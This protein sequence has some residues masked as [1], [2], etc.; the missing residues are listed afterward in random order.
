MLHGD[1][2]RLGIFEDTIPAVPATETE[3][4]PLPKAATP[5]GAEATR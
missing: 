5:T 3:E 4:R 2:L 1:G